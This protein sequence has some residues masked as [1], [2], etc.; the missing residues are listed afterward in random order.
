MRC[1]DYPRLREK[2]WEEVLPCG[3]RVLALH[4]PDFKR[5]FAVVSLNY[6][7]ADLRWRKDGAE[8][9]APAG[10]A[11]YLEHKLFDMPD[12]SADQQFAALGGNPNAF[13]GYCGTSYYVETTCQPAENLRLLLQM[14]FTPWFTTES[15]ERERGVIGQEIKMSDDSPDSRLMEFLNEIALPGHPL[16]VPI[17]GTQASIAQITA[18]TLNRCYADFYR[19]DNM[20]LCVE[21]PLPPEQ[22][23][24]IAAACAPAAPCGAVRSCFAEAR[25]KPPLRGVQTLRMDVAMPMFAAGFPLPPVEGEGERLELACDLA[26]EILIG[27]SSDCYRR[28]YDAGLIDESFSAGC[29][30]FRNLAMLSFSGDSR[31]PEAVVAEICAEA[32]RLCREGVK[33]EDLDRLKKAMFGHFVRLLDGF[34]PTC[35]RLAE[36]ALEG[37]DYLDFP[38][39]IAA[40]TEAEILDLLRR[41]RPE[42][43]SVAVILPKEEE[44]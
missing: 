16:S 30:R 42:A 3:L 26:V 10:T 21:G 25:P 39:R 8:C 37:T 20:V 28:L 17:L 15:V 14:V 13:T 19:P 22:V 34:G 31:D 27:T 44:D 38:A 7:G 41:I 2:V 23:L 24:E 36:S 35:I 29:D 32:D 11:H 1:R 33:P 6:G 4:K 43:A 12:G 5:S 40:V 9:E 18:E